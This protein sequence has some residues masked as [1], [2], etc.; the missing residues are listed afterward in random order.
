MREEDTVCVGVMVCNTV[1][2]VGKRKKHFFLRVDL[3][4]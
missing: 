2:S 1:K 4:G 3:W